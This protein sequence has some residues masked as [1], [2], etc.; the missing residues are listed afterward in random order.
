MIVGPV[1]PDDVTGLRTASAAAQELVLATRIPDD[2][3]GAIRA[4]YRSLCTAGREVPVAVRSSATAEDAATASFAGQLDTFLWVSGED[5]VIRHVQR[6]WA[7]LYSPSALTYRVQPQA[8]RGEVAMG[9]VVQEMVEAR[10]AGVLFTLNPLNGDRSKVMIEASFGLGE[11]VVAGEVN[12]DRYLLDKVTLEVLERT[13]ARKE[14]EYRFDPALGTAVRGAVPAERQAQPCLSD[15]EV[16]A[17][18]RTGK[19]VERG[20]GSPQDVEWAI[21]TAGNTS[22][23]IRVLQMR[24]ETVWSRR[25]AQPLIGVKGNAV[26]YVLASLLARGSE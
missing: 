19:T 25:E 5:E 12:P 13:V 6:A 22:E 11:A 7:G 17:L 18:A 1:D 23:R 10:A 16:V 20:A 14:V 21:G 8:A 2:V 24:P 26:D 4:A 15:E 3:A 9:V